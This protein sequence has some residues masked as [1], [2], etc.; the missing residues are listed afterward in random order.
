M[1]S[2]DTGTVGRALVDF[3]LQGNF[4][5]ED[6]SSCHVAAQDFVPALESL[7]AAKTKLEVG[8]GAFPAFAHRA[9]A[10]KV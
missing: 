8:L 9:V 4:P 5:D 3:A 2:A 10:Y 7:A 1:A 6:V